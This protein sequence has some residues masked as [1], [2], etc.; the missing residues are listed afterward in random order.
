MALRHLKGVDSRAHP[1][2]MDEHEDQR[3]LW[4]A[5][6][7]LIKAN[8]ALETIGD[9][10]LAVQRELRRMRDEAR[11]E[12]ESRLPEDAWTVL[13]L[14]RDDLRVEMAGADEESS[15][16]ADTA[17]LIGISTAAA[18][19]IAP[20]G[21]WLV[22]ESIIKELIKASVGALFVGMATTAAEFVIGRRRDTARATPERPDHPAPPA[23]TRSYLIAQDLD[24]GSE[25]GATPMSGQFPLIGMTHLTGAAPAAAPD[26][27][28]ESLRPRPQGRDFRPG[29]Q[30]SHG[31]RWNDSPIEKDGPAV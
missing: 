9:S 15:A 23:P 14:R 18:I 19:L 11:L 16:F 1:D 12:V 6:Q 13:E 30:G 7:R 20:F 24:A 21:A 5:L 2:P 28:A 29:E 4:T 26:D 22:A 31:L 25:R 10:D 17:L 27:A 8:S 3:L